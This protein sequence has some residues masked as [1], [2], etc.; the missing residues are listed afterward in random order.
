MSKKRFFSICDVS[1]DRVKS[2]GDFGP[3]VTQPDESLTIQQILVRVSQGL[4]TGVGESQRAEDYDD[5]GDHDWDDPTRQ[6]GFDRLDALE[7]QNSELA[8]KTRQEARKRKKDAD[9]KEKNDAFQK[10]V[11]EEIQRRQKKE[12]PQE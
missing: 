12:E 7:Y 4:T 10:A 6:P 2:L 8:E 3:S 1:P 11:D 9:E 5:E